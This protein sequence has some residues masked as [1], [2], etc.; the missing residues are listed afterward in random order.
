MPSAVAAPAAAAKPER[1]PRV[2]P[3]W[4]I[5]MAMAPTGAAIAN[6]ATAPT[7]IASSTSG[8][9]GNHGCARWLDQPDVSQVDNLAARNAQ[10]SRSN[11]LE[12]LEQVGRDEPAQH[13]ARRP[14]W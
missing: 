13:R 6:P 4:I 14:E 12:L 2:S 1:I 9:V 11:L 3:V 7:T 8:R 5:R 10:A